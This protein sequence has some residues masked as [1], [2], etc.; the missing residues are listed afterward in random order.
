V[1]LS[2]C[3]DCSKLC[4][5]QK[6]VIKRLLRVVKVNDIASH[7]K[8]ASFARA[9]QKRV[10]CGPPFQSHTKRISPY[11][12]IIQS[13]GPRVN[14]GLSRSTKSSPIPSRRQSIIFGPQILVLCYNL[15]E[16]H[17]RGHQ[18]YRVYNNPSNSYLFSPI[19]YINMT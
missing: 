4:S 13:E 3:V 10:K 19:E 12:K 11:P 5:Q 2:Y 8:N 16:K 9:D 17:P 6:D 14:T 7:G 15:P 18:N 1:D